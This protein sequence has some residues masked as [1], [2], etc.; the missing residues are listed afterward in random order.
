SAG[1]SAAGSPGSNGAWS[2]PR[3]PT[4]PAP[5][6]SEPAPHDSTRPRGDVTW[7]THGPPRVRAMP[8][9]EPLHAIVPA[10]GAGTRLWPLSRRDAPKF[11]H[12][13]TGSGRTLIQQTYDRL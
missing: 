9:P 3:R 1:G 2:A 4:P 7:A 11:L 6:G 8:H 10:G 5:A 12:D 13:L